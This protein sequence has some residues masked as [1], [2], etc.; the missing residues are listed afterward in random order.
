MSENKD[1]HISENIKEKEN[2]VKPTHI[3]CN[4]CGSCYHK[5]NKTKHVLT[6]KHKD[7]EYP[8]TQKFE[9]IR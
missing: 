3:T 1:K 6:K 4:V 5:V 2:V 9:I 8:W 7:C